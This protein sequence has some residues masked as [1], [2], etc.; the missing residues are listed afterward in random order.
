MIFADVPL[1][2]GPVQNALLTHSGIRVDY[3]R[4]DKKTLSATA[5]FVRAL[6]GEDED[7]IRRLMERLNLKAY[8]FDDTNDGVE[9]GDSFMMFAPKNRLGPVYFGIF[10][11]FGDDVLPL[12]IQ[13]PHEGT[14][15]AFRVSTEMWCQ[16][17]A[18]SMVFNYCAKGSAKDQKNGRAIS[19]WAHVTPNA[20]HTACQAAWGLIDE[21]SVV[22][23]HG[24]VGSD[25]SHLLVHATGREFPENSFPHFFARALQMYFPKDEQEKF[26]MGD[27]KLAYANVF[28][29]TKGAIWSPQ[30]SLLR[31]RFIHLET[32][33]AFR[34]DEKHCAQRRDKLNDA[35][36]EAAVARAKWLDDK[37]SADV[38]ELSGHDADE[39]L[40]AEL[41]RGAGVI[42][43]HVKD[44]DE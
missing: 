10:F 20:G 3:K 24:M 4:P 28:G 33:P 18:Q 7:E 11:R 17:K 14:D 40:E 31:G 32:A 15:G 38:R 6:G 2:K 27:R 5:A 39:E 12:C 16:T 26:K 36:I 41:M 29:D 9:K 23:I 22:Q 42:P 25:Q 1:F 44:G 35:I 19:D 43:E 13:S 30:G 8:R 37:N 21:S 34:G